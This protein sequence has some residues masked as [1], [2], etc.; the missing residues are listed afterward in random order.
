VRIS[1]DDLHLALRL[2]DINVLDSHLL[3]I[4][5]CES[6]A[7]HIGVNGDRKRALYP[8]QSLDLLKAFI[9]IIQAA[10][11]Y[12]KQNKD[13]PAILEQIDSVFRQYISATSAAEEFRPTV[14]LGPSAEDYLRDEVIELDGIQARRFVR[15]RVDRGFPNERELQVFKLFMDA[16]KEA[17]FNTNISRYSRKARTDIIPDGD[18]GRYLRFNFVKHMLISRSTCVGGPK[19]SRV[20]LIVDMFGGAGDVGLV[21]WSPDIVQPMGRYYD[22]ERLA[23]TDT[24]SADQLNAM[25][26][27]IMDALVSGHYLPVTESPKIVVER[28]T[29]ASVLPEETIALETEATP[30][31]PAPLRLLP[32]DGFVIEEAIIPI[33]VAEEWLLQSLK[34]WADANAIAV[35][36]L[37]DIGTASPVKADDHS[38]IGVSIGR[39]EEVKTW[40]EQQV[41]TDEKTLSIS[42]KLGALW[43]ELTGVATG[44]HELCSIEKLLHDFNDEELDRAMRI[45]VNQYIRRQSGSPD[46]AFTKLGGICINERR[47]TK[48]VNYYVAIVRNHKQGEIDEGETAQVVRAALKLGFNHDTLVGETGDNEPWQTWHERMV[49]LLNTYSQR[50]ADLERALLGALLINPEPLIEVIPILRLEDF[51]T[52]I[53]Q[54]IFESMCY[55]VQEG[56]SVDLITVR[57][58]IDEEV[59]EAVGGLAYLIELTEIETQT[60]AEAIILYAKEVRRYAT[61][62]REQGDEPVISSRRNRLPIRGNTPSAIQQKEGLV[63]GLWPRI[64]GPKVAEGTQAI[65]LRGNCLVIRARNTVW[66]NELMLLKRDI[67]NRFQQHTTERIVS[68]IR[69]EVGSVASRA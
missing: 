15:I 28:P 44:P 46:H 55:L 23:E 25:L 63:I 57:D 33:R 29:E 18:V 45:A 32:S 1:Y 69:F 67:I 21:T 36:D 59:L 65:G 48:G 6:I 39:F 31:H 5:K 56:S 43:T 52:Q 51:R 49:K 42:E 60:T 54:A 40:L 53:N 68:D 30:D 62:R 3:K 10:E 2:R 38:L 35:F 13:L 4:L 19:Y 20:P 66:A 11:L 27:Y 9:P 47:G 64:V 58:D 34:K 26:I 22:R 17:D 7:N 41:G 8:I 12:P 61:I 24:L 37:S 50:A 16:L 14:T